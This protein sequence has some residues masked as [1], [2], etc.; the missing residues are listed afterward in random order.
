[1]EI[2]NVLSQ[3]IALIGAGVIIWGFVLIFTRFLRLEW[4]RI[5]GRRIGPQREALRHQLG[6]YLLLGLEMLIAA[7]VLRTVFHPTLEELGLLAGI[8]V[9]RT[10]I[11]SFL[12]KELAAS[13]S[14][15]EVITKEDKKTPPAP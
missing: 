14:P 4:V 6:S 8:V 11:S 15:V 10:I 9:I 5:R 13:H 7:D 2:L 1:M 12:D 3:V